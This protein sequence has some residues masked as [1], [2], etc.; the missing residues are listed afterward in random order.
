MKEF[1]DK[2][3]TQENSFELIDNLNTLRNLLLEMN[4]PQEP[5]TYVQMAEDSFKIL[6]KYGFSV[7]EVLETM[8]E[9]IN[10]LEFMEIVDLKVDQ[11]L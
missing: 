5:R 6:Q 3:K 2:C 1:A 11:T 8:N 9:K 10:F 4:K 7:T